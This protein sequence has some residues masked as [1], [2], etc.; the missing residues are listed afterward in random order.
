MLYAPYVRIPFSVYLDRMGA[1]ARAPAPVYPQ[2]GW[3]T[4]SIRFNDAVPIT[5]NDVRAQAERFDRVWLVQS[6]VRLFGS[7]DPRYQAV[8]SGLA[9]ADFDEAAITRFDGVEVRRFERR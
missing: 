4:S 6:H 5:A 7:D 8:L 3:E 1:V 2:D 9:G